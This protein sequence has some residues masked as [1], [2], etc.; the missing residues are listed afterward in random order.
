V[1]RNLPRKPHKSIY[2]VV[3]GQISLEGAP[4]E[5]IGHRA[6]QRLWG[7]RQTGFAH[8]V[9]PGAN[10]TRL[11]HSLGVYFVAG[12]MADAL[13]LA[14]HEREE[15]VCGGLLHDLG[16]G[17]FSH[18]LDGPMQEVLGFGHEKISRRWI[19]GGGPEPALR[20]PETGPSIPEILERHGLAPSPIAD[21]VDPPRHRDRRPLLRS[22]LHG[23][24]D[25]DRLDY[26]QRDTHYTG[27]G[28]GAI[29]TARLLDTVEVE[30]GRLLFAEKGR[31]AVEGFLL[32]RTLMYSSVYYHKTVRAAEVM[33]SSA[34]ERLPGYPEA[35]RELF[36]LTDGDLLAWLGGASEY[37]RSISVALRERR[38]FKRVAGWRELPAGRRRPVERWARRPAER[39]QLE[40]EL[41]Q[42]L[43]APDG[44]L[45]V[46][47]SGCEPRLADAE[48]LAEI[49]VREGPRVTHPFEENPH[50]RSLL[51]R[52]PSAWALAVYVHPGW[53]H[54]AE[55]RLP[56]ALERY[57]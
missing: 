32:G 4:L 13:G 23:P 22:I 43:G 53:R 56:R 49:A 41:A 44:A 8:L 47:L 52:P 39:R 28:H 17:P 57:L 46:D 1:A 31:S 37:A 9:F 35:A 40:A 6:F 24:I 14:P 38:L 10:H 11:E 29:D 50:W 19:V 21:L 34:V 16:H 33:L 26:L 15:V 30:R 12:R 7:V 5:L 48:D 3:H 27:V 25:A 54:V 55:E 18:T 20:A 36:G 45:L 2:D 42:L 51:L